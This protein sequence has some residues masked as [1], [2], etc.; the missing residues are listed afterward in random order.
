MQSKTLILGKTSASLACK[1]LV[2]SLDLSV[3]IRVIVHFCFQCCHSVLIKEGVWRSLQSIQANS[4]IGS[5]LS[6]T[7][8]IDAIKASNLIIF[9]VF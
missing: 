3:V 8:I 1:A 5:R 7:A 2:S 9:Y 4:S 6:V